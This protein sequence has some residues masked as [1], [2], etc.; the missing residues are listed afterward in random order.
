[1]SVVS[2]YNDIN[3]RGL[4]EVVENFGR[5]LTFADIAQAALTF[6]PVPGL[7]Q[8]FALGRGAVN[9]Y[10]AANDLA[11]RAPGFFGPD[12]MGFGSSMANASL[13][14]VL[15]I[16][17]S[18]ADQYS[19]AMA[20]GGTMEAGE[21]IGHFGK[22]DQDENMGNTA[23]PG[24]IA[25]AL[26]TA[27]EEAGDPMDISIGFLGDP[28][29]QDDIDLGIG[30]DE[31]SVSDPDTVGDNVSIGENDATVGMEDEYGDI[32]DSDDAGTSGDA[33]SVICTE[34]H[35]QGLVPTHLFEG[36]KRH[37]RHLA[38]IDPALMS[39][40]HSWGKPVARWMKHSKLLTYTMW[41]IAYPVIKE[42]AAK[43]GRGFGSIIGK[44]ILFIGIPICR[45]IGNIKLRSVKPISA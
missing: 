45:T 35:R 43:Q 41:L 15:G 44:A 36:D 9:A 17:T 42:L 40:Y 31:S 18:A 28:F 23:T 27:R 19:N 22:G 6:A 5:G 30:E 4:G 34:L 14:G 2:T 24:S 8:G 16:G 26:A 7:S 39:G 37:G 12:D 38:K 25:H 20:I 33:T 29:T 11:D 32:E 13:L 1:M 21:G 10:S 3:N